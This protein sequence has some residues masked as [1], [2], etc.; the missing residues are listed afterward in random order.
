MSGALATNFGVHFFPN[1]TLIGQ[2]SSHGQT[3]GAKA[4]GHDY[5]L[6]EPNECARS[7]G[8]ANPHSTTSKR[9]TSTMS[10]LI[11]GLPQVSAPPKNLKTRVSSMILGSC[12]ERLNVL[13][14]HLIFTGVKSVRFYFGP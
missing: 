10:S 11:T 13:W 5:A 8:W 2:A 3:G 7:A 12:V 9:S 4:D 14:K 6:S 1:G